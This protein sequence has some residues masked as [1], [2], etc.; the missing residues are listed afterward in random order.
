MIQLLCGGGYWSASEDGA[1]ACLMARW[2]RERGPVTYVPGFNNWPT[3]ALPSRAQRT[4]LRQA[5]GI[6]MGV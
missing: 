3:A 1:V 6:V 5:P 2:D 4:L